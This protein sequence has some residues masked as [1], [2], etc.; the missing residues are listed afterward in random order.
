MVFL[1]AT[2]ANASEFAAW[3]AHLHRQP[4]HVVYTDYRPTPLH[5]FAF[6]AGGGGLY[7]IMD[8]R[9]N[10]RRDNFTK[11]Q[12][13]LGEQY[14][15]TLQQS[16]RAQHKATSLLYKSGHLVHSQFA[17]SLARLG[18]LAA[19]RTLASCTRMRV[20]NLES[21]KAFL[22]IKASSAAKCVVTGW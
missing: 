8:E 2:L 21:S 10:F 22:V 9:G 13:S 6:P 14:F 17:A 20:H 16:L 18:G 7:L 4:C 5:H 19:C 11:L 3:V 1:S 15:T 12:E